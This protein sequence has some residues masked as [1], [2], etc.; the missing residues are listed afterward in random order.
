MPMDYLDSI[1]HLALPFRVTDEYAIQCLQVLVAANLIEATFVPSDAPGIDR[2]ADVRAI[3]QR[4][5]AALESYRRGK[6]FG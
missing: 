5:R 1:D 2:A 4:G 3:T 6:T